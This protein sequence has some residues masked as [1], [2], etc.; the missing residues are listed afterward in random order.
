MLNVSSFVLSRLPM[1]KTCS[2]SMNVLSCSLLQDYMQAIAALLLVLRSLWVH[3]QVDLTLIPEANGTTVVQACLAKITGANIFSAN[4]M[5][6]R[7]AYVETRDGK[8]SDTYTP[9]NNGGI[10]QLSKSKYLQT[11]GSSSVLTAPVS[12]IS[13]SFG[14]TWSTTQWV[15]LR[16]PLYSAL[17]A[18]LY[19]YLIS[20]S[21]PLGTNI[22][23]QASYW[24]NQYT[25][26]AGT[27]S[28]FTS[29][30]N[31]L[32]SSTGSV[33]CTACHMYG[34][35]DCAV[36]QSVVLMGWTYTL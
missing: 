17:A 1:Y 23:G 12:S 10:W 34:Y 25:S 15:D 24:V 32:Q 14:I 28:D 22:N 2:S 5:L 27:T 3:S 13:S 33:C 36:F 19:L 8:D 21:I 26:S 29:A 6:R 35:Y 7:I 20:T 18:R 30:V 9:T 31:F 11:K 4:Q 16:K